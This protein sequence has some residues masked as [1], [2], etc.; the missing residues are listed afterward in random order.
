VERVLGPS[1]HSLGLHRLQVEL[2]ALEADFSNLTPE[3]DRYL[4]AFE[5]GKAEIDD[6]DFKSRMEVHSTVQKRLRAC[7]E[8]LLPDPAGHRARHA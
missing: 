5:G 1:I 6:E 3:D 4:D 2:H 8:E 7:R